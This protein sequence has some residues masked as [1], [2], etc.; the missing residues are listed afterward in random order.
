METR[1]DS[2]FTPSIW[3]KRYSTPQEVLDAHVAFAKMG[4]HSIFSC[5]FFILQCLS[6]CSTSYNA[7]CLFTSNTI[8]FDC[9]TLHLC[10]YLDVCITFEWPFS[11]VAYYWVLRCKRQLFGV[12]FRI[13]N[14][15]WH[16]NL[17]EFGHM[18]N[19]YKE[20]NCILFFVHWNILCHWQAMLMQK[21]QRKR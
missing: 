4:K 10:K 12:R 17:N 13:C 20:K 7:F 2:L 8:C 14:Q 9:M 21:L 11:D 6:G 1:M 18:N 16:F 5:Q 19:T 3:S 15:C